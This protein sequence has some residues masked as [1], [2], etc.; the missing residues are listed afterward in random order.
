M[1]KPK[2]IYE[3]ML[4]EWK[5]FI[6]YDTEKEAKVIKEIQEMIKDT[7]ATKSKNSTKKGK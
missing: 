5:K 6:S 3:Y 4:Y 2:T 1:N 7:P